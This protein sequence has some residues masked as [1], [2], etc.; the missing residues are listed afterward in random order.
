MTSS[1]SVGTVF[2]DWYMLNAMFQAWLVKITKIA[3][4]SAPSTRPGNR[5]MKK[6][7]VKVRNPRI[8]I[9]CRM[10]STG[11]RMTPARRDFAAHTG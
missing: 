7:T 10:S 2:S 11:T 1:R 3:A 4:S 9:D 5:F 6:V 8:G